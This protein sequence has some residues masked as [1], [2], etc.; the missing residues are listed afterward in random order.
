MQGKHI[1]FLTR[2]QSSITKNCRVNNRKPNLLSKNLTHL[3]ILRIYKPG[4]KI[5]RKPTA[6]NYKTPLS[7][8][9][10]SVAFPFPSTLRS[11]TNPCNFLIDF[12]RH[13]VSNCPLLFWVAGNTKA[14]CWSVLWCQKNVAYYILVF[15][16]HIW[17]H[18]AVGY[19]WSVKTY[20]TLTYRTRVL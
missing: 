3:R 10:A 6:S 19:L 12:D 11:V 2:F 13:H 20:V 14:T 9:A 7:T 4:F 16:S 15:R 5:R 17:H 1:G 18:L 8:E